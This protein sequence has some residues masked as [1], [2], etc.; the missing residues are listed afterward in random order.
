MVIYPTRRIKVG[1]VLFA[2]CSRESGAE[3]Q[4]RAASLDLACALREFRKSQKRS[5]SAIDLQRGDKGFLRNVDFAELSHLLFAFLL[6]FEKFSFARDVAAI[7][8]R[9][10]ILA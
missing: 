7:A 2:G 1:T 10:D 8:L 6:L 4:Q 9:G 3:A 5:G